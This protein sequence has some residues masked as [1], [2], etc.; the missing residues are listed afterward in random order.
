MLMVNVSLPWYAKIVNFLAC[1]VFPPE[2]NSQQ[3]KKLLHD[4]RFYQWDDLLL[5]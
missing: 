3:R 2:L 4:A 5:F 1:K